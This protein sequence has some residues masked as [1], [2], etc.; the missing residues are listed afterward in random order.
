VSGLKKAAIRAGLETLYFSG[1]HQLMRPFCGGVGAILTLHHVRPARRDRFQPNKLLEITPHFLDAVIRQLKRWDIDFVSLDEVHRRLTEGDFSRRFVSFTLDDA[2]VDHQAYAQP[3]FAK[4]GVPFAVY[5]P[6]GF[7]DR[8]GELW[9]LVLEDVIAKHDQISLIMNGREAHVR[10][11]TLAEKFEAY[12]QLYWWL[13][14]LTTDAEIRMI[15]R[16]LAARYRVDMGAICE[17]LCL[18]WDGIAELAK[19]PLVTLGAHTVNHP[20]LAKLPEDQ[21]TTELRMGRA[22]MES[23]IGV[24]A[25]HLAYPF[26]QIGTAGPR[27]FRI[28][29]EL[30]YK[31]AVVT[32]PGVLFPEH[33]EHLWALPR[34]SLNGEYQQLRH[35]RVLMSGAATAIWNGFR[36]VNAA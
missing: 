7:T 32:R 24:R 2:Y 6:T 8:F 21:A 19:D 33:A 28:A 18:T 4:H 26:G 35:L 10:C 17:K 12:D 1:A 25:E 16:D 14:G 36:R 31:T 30:G 22:V 15:A 23:A 11:R 3:V 29:Q 5:V 20:I 27:E 34:I 13:R 9:W